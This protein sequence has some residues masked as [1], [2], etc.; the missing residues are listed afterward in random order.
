MA[1]VPLRC[2]TG[3][4]GEQ[5]RMVE[6]IWWPAK[7]IAVKQFY[8][9]S[10]DMRGVTMKLE[11]LIDVDKLQQLLQRFYEINGIGTAIITSEGAI[12]TETGWQEVCVKFHRSHP[13]TAA[14]CKQS[15]IRVNRAIQ[16]GEK[17]V[18]YT[19]PMGLVD[20]CCPINVRGRHLANIFTGQFFHE[21]LQQEDWDRFRKQAATFGF[22]EQEYLQAVGAVPVISREKHDS[23]LSFLGT[24]AELIITMASDAMALTEAKRRSEQRDSENA[25]LSRQLRQAQKIEAIGT[26][27]G[28]IAHDF[29]NILGAMIG[30]TDMAIEDV[31]PDSRIG[32]DLQHVLDAGQRAKELVGQILTFSRQKETDKAILQPASVIKEA[33]KMLRSTLPSTI[34]IHQEIE[35]EAGTVCADP[36]QLHQVVVNICTNA[37]HA[38]EENGGE[39]IIGLRQATWL[40]PQIRRNAERLAAEYVEISMQDTGSGMPPEVAVKIFDPFFTTKVEGKGTGMGLS[41]V[42]GIVSELGGAVTVDSK[43]GQG[44]IFRIFLPKA[45]HVEMEGATLNGNLPGGTESI[46]FVDDEKVLVDMVRAK[47]ERL[48]YSVV[49]ETDGRAALDLFTSD[50]HAFDI[51]ITDFTMPGM[52]GLNLAKRMLEV[53]PVLPIIICTGYSEL[54]DRESAAAAGVEGFLQK[55]VLKEDMAQLVRHLLDS[56]TAASSCA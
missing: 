37:Y 21:P 35:P 10:Q 45:Q 27:A 46:L 3:P 53:R 13:E 14:L 49:G 18:S 15:D 54:L 50:P 36:V 30:Y 41:I 16:R 56:A 4:D 51:V 7:S 47:L 44:T 25:Q 22:A 17:S 40:P 19:C 52:N 34:S 29:N 33:V 11:Q 26:L 6:Y 23:I 12:L 28:G 43:V 24:F 2:R 39:L 31:Q 1:F 32:Q 5:G 8:V 48:G 38:M 42:H 55:P 20:S 9:R